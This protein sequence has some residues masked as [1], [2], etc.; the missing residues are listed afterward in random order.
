MKT[1]VA[2]LLGA[3]GILAANAVSAADIAVPSMPGP[4]VV[5]VPVETGFEW[6][7]FFAG[8]QGGAWYELDPGAFDSFRGATMVGRNI[9]LGDRFVVGAEAV[10]GF[11]YTAAEGIFFDTMGMARAG[12]LLG[13]RALAYGTIGIGFDFAPL[14]G[15]FMVA[16]GGVEVGAGVNLGVRSEILA[17]RYLGEPVSFISGTVGLS[18]YFGR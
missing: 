5:V 1:T 9:V 6:N 13:D 3:L 11:Y 14:G 16:G 4:V 8:V 2:T 10:G 15:A 7:R 18:W 17:F 12:I